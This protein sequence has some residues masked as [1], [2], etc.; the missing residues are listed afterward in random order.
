MVKEMKK[1]FVGKF[2]RANLGKLILNGM[3]KVM[4]I[5]RK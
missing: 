1:I 2:E 5:L 3:I 4:P